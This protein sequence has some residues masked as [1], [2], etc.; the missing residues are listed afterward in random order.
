MDIPDNKVARVDLEKGRT[1][2]EMISN[3]RRKMFLGGDGLAA[4]YVFD[5]IAADVDPLG[6]AN[7][8]VI[9]VGALTG[10][11]MVSCNRFEV[12]AKSPLTN[13]YGESCAGG[14]WG[15]ALRFTGHEG[16]IIENKSE[17]PVYLLVDNEGCEI[18][19][20]V[21][22]WGKDTIET[23]MALKSELENEDIRMI[24]IGQGGENLVKIAAIID[25]Q[26]HA[27]GRTGMGA[28][29]GSKNLKAIVVKKENRNKLKVADTNL[30]LR[31]NR[32]IRQKIRE[33][34]AVQNTSK[35]GTAGGVK[36]AEL[37][38][39][40]PIKNWLLSSWP[41][42]ANQLSG[43][44]LA[45]KYLTRRRTCYG[46]P[47]GCKRVV[48]VKAGEFAV[49]ETHG[50]EYETL[51]S[52]GTLLLNNNLEA[53][54]KMND[55]CTRY[56]LDTISCG[57]VIAF[58]VESHEKGLLNHTQI[59]AYNLKFGEPHGHIELIKA[60]AYKKGLGRVLGE[61]V[62]TAANILGISGHHVLQVKGLELPMHDPRALDSFALAYATSN[63]GACHLQASGQNLEAGVLFPELG[64]TK[65][66]NRLLSE[67]KAPIIA[68][69]QHL[70]L[71]LDSIGLCRIPVGSGAISVTDI[72][73]GLSAV[74][75]RDF[76][77]EE[78]DM[79]GERVFNLKRLFNVSAG[80]AKKDDC[81]PKRLIAPTHGHNKWHDLNL[82]KQLIEYYKIRGWTKD[83]KPETETLKR[84][85]LD[86]MITK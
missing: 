32:S 19:D 17:R 63:R 33:N 67:G 56:G 54:I 4:S 51:G 48:Q 21:H 76:T 66:S 24:A 68:K 22:L 38:G 2:Y 7:K 71:V 79:I 80:V 73:T 8:L 69:T 11:G 35:Y 60:I 14:F 74:F 6:K 40:M 86:M 83:G 82:E 30:L 72:V 27:A 23:F 42:G 61:G 12:A 36:N 18:R 1:T 78:I 58:A 70:S 34:T 47:V 10:T 77:V 65:K 31:T 57:S 43:Q 49:E 25:D 15:P 29:M 64:L 75:G 39:D 37:I 13:I 3:E 5:E 46:C 20:A 28:V 53:V 59:G 16:I 44:S 55:L 52:F 45:N 9:I 85:R 50:P 26:G 81:L 41:E 62:R 84:L